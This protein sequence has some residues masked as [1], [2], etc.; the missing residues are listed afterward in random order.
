[1]IIKFNRGPHNGHYEEVR[2]G[3]EVL[4]V[5]RVANLTPL[6]NF[7]FNVTYDVG[8]YRKSNVK[9]KNGAVVF[10]WMGW[11]IDEVQD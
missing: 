10:E 7:G 9:L 2:D 5:R 4:E 11:R 1:M 6:H 3:I 8:T